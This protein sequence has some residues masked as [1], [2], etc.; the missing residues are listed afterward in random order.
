MDDGEIRPQTHTCVP[1]II[2]RSNQS[3]KLPLLVKHSRITSVYI[4]RLENQKKIKERE[5]ERERKRDGAS[6]RER[7]RE[8]EREREKR[9]TMLT[10]DPQVRNW[11]MIPITFAMLLIGIL[12]HLVAKVSLKSKRRKKEEEERILFSNFFFQFFPPL[13]F[14]LFFPSQLLRGSTTAKVKSIQAKQLVQRSQ[15]LRAHSSFLNRA[16]FAQRKDYFC[17][18]E[19]GKFNQKVDPS[20]NPQAQMMSDPS[21]LTDML[22]KNLTMV[23]PQV[24]NFYK[25]RNEKIR[26]TKKKFLS[27]NSSPE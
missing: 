23:V 13:F 12:R 26:K 22:T 7:E 25:T 8:G 20:L 1:F 5:R 24:R 10:L 21:M 18:K 4:S 9:G 16:A 6:A 19:K 11:V 2:H 27:R 15:Y 17:E 3:M 14:F